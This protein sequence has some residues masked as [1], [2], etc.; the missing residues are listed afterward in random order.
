MT[1][2]RDEHD[3]DFML[4]KNDS[5]FSIIIPFYQ[6]PGIHGDK[7]FE[8]LKQCIDSIHQN[9]DM[10]FEIIVHDDSAEYSNIEKIKDK[11]S[12]VIR[13]YG[14]NIG[15][16]ESANRAI[17]LASSN[18]ILFLNDDCK[19][20]RRC[21]KSY[22]TV[23]ERPYVGMIGA[24]GEPPEYPHNSDYILKYKDVPFFPTY[25]VG[26]CCIMVF[27]KDFW[28]EVGGFER[29]DSG[30]SD[31]V[32]PFKAWKHGYFRVRLFGPSPF[33]NMSQE[34]KNVDTTL[35]PYPELHMPKLFHI[36]LN[37]YRKMCEQRALEF[38]RHGKLEEFD[39]MGLA[40]LNYWHNTSQKIVPDKDPCHIN[41]EVSTFNHIRFRGE[42]LADAYQ[43]H[44]NDGISQFYDA[45]KKK[46]ELSSLYT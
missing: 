15:L 8:Y 23:L 28:K 40:N 21:L 25:G 3:L 32:I 35:G 5:F 27:R 1:K 7:R 44:E 29:F 38:K 13:N 18:N 10:P 9:A 6:P 11:I 34:I 4:P 33:R 30:R 43:V 16:A 31:T 42:L 19:M 2:F 12:I 46:L 45:Y 14:L 39:L 17:S 36:T 37:D 22:K 41:W 24:F 20:I 26:G